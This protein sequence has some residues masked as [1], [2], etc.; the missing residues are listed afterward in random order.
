MKQ[1][2]ALFATTAIKLPWPLP[3]LL[4]WAAAWAVFIIASRFLKM[5]PF[6]AVLLA[7]GIAVAFSLRGDTRWRRIFIAWGFPLSLGASGLI[8]DLP[9]WAWLL[10]L[11]LAAVVYPVHTW[12]D[13]PLFPTPADALKD[14]PGMVQLPDGARILDAGCGLGDGLIELHRAYPNAQ[15]SG[16]EWSWPLRFACAVRTRFANVRRGDIW[17]ADWSAYDMVY[18]FQRPETMSRA[19]TKAGRELRPGAWMASLEFKVPDLAP[20]CTLDCPDGRRVW[21]YQAPIKHR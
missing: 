13:A 19:A 2:R 6:V 17:S 18:L 15:L 20:T 16:L 9:A 3:A 1:A 12:R 14:L 11:A 10:P 7:A 5:S 21:L 4:I 8:G